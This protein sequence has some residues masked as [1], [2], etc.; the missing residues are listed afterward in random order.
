MLLGLAF[1]DQAFAAPDLTSPEQ[2]FGLR[3]GSNQ[4]ELPIP[5]NHTKAEMPLF[6]RLKSTVHGVRVSPVD[7]VT[8]NWLRE[9]KARLGAVTGFELPVGPYCFR[10]GAGEA[11]DSSSASPIRWNE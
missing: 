3:V 5:I 6:R 1:S 9:S 8:D 10:R 2:L 11:L 4:L 7:A